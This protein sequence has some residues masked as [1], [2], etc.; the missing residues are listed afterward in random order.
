MRNGHQTVHP[1]QKE[2]EVTMIV[3]PRTFILLTTILLTTTLV[4]GCAQIGSAG[5]V[6]ILSSADLVSTHDGGFGGAP[7]EFRRRLPLIAFPPIQWTNTITGTA[8]NT[9]AAQTGTST[10]YDYNEGTIRFAA[11]TGVE[12][13]APAGNNESASLEVDFG[14]SFIADNVPAAWVAF[15]NIP[16]SGFVSPGGSVEFLLDLEVRISRFDLTEV[17]PR[18]ELGI[19]FFNVHWVNDTPGDFNTLLSD[20][21]PLGSTGGWSGPFRDIM[22]VRGSIE[23][24]S[25][26]DGGPTNI[27]APEGINFGSDPV[28]EPTA[29]TLALAALCLAMSRRRIAAR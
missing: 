7:H 18:E 17:V 26:N 19:H 28:P 23:F 20:I 6:D 1:C 29:A 24:R 5:I 12:Q 10:Y 15:Y 4:L 13:T 22:Y 14:V 11:G 21:V 3:P 8:A 9:S 25:K 27:I 2:K 16:L